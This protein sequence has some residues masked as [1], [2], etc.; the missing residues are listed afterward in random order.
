MN[1]FLKPVIAA[2][3]GLLSAVLEATVPMFILTAAF[4]LADV[5]TAMRLQRRLKASG[6]IKMEDARF[7]SAKFGRIVGTLTKILCLL[8]LTAMV[9]HL[10]LVPLGIGA[11]KFV[12]GAVCFW[13]AISLLENEAAHNDAKWAVCARKF[14][15]DKAR[16]YI[17]EKCS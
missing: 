11:M 5:V 15:V 14:L 3:F 7:S 13:Q 4:V 2:V 12:A 8:L 1:T 9:D 10:V 6:K 16:R 17:H